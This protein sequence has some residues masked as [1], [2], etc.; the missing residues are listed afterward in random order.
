MAFP[1]FASVHCRRWYLLTRQSYSAHFLIPQRA[2]SQQFNHFSSLKKGPR[3][4]ISSFNEI[5]TRQ[6][7]HGYGNMKLKRKV[8]LK[9][10]EWLKREHDRN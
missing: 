3:K 10:S 9:T 2:L 6:S 7:D 4:E 8:D 5:K 1:V